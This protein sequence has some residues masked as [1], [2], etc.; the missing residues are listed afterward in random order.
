MEPGVHRPRSRV[1]FR[2]ER[3]LSGAAGLPGA[4]GPTTE[5]VEMEAVGWKAQWGWRWSEQWE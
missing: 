1:E 5:R 2:A 3:L 4:F